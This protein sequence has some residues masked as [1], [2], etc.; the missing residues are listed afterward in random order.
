ML[1]TAVSFIG[2]SSAI[3]TG[4]VLGN[5]RDA[6]VAG[7]TNVSAEGS[8]IRA[9]NDALDDLPSTASGPVTVA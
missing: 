4:I 6:L 5:K 1:K 2:I 7:T 8:A 3:I 9:M